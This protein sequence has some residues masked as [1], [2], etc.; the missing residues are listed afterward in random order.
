MA[1]VA[2]ARRMWRTGRRHVAG[3]HA[4][5]RVHVDARVGRHVAG[6]VGSWRAHGYSGSWLGIGGGNANALLHPNI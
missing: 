2:H 6:A 4:C 1:A 3:G 5:P